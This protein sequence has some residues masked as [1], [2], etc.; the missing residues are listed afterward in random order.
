MKTTW[1]KCLG[2]A[3]SYRCCSTSINTLLIIICAATIWLATYVGSNIYYISRYIP[4]NSVTNLHYDTSL[5]L[6]QN[7]IDYE[8]K[9]QLSIPLRIAG[10]MKGIVEADV[11]NALPKNTRLVDESQH[12]TRAAPLLY[13]FIAHFPVSSVVV[14]VEEDGSLIGTFETTITCV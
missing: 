7:R 9:T 12:R 4:L 13:N 10:T 8:I 6:L 2:F 14:G 3:W 1:L 5:N 11:G